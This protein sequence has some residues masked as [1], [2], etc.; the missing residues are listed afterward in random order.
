MGKIAI[1]GAGHVGGTAASFI[2][3]E[4]NCD[5]VLLDIDKDRAK[6]L[7][8]DLEHLASFENKDI[9][10]I[11]TNR[12]SDIKNSDIVI[13]AAGMPRKK[14]MKREDL[15]K[16]NISI[17]KDIAKKIRRYCKKAVIV[18]VTNPV[19]IL[20]YVV[21]KITKLPRRKIIGLGNN[22]DLARLRK[23]VSKKLG[24]K[25]RDVRGMVIGCHNSKVMV[26]LK[27]RIKIKGRPLGEVVNKKDMKEVL[28]KTKTA[29]SEIVSLMKKGSA[30]FAPAR[31]VVEL[32]DAIINNK[33]KIIPCSVFYKGVFIGLPC[34]IGKKGV[35]KII[36]PEMEE[37][38]KKE[39]EKA[40]KYLKEVVLSYKNERQNNKRTFR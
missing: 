25:V 22:L 8:L 26:I 30:Y 3:K 14:G 1:I 17:I 27:S 32:I 5:I 11:G 31:A 6:A 4:F 36:K 16:I 38:E 35:E 15:L 37:D 24:C 2:V 9:K 28:E 34:V 40:L 33:K 19:D 10:I 7:A 23:I 29:G 18:V 12:Y 13:I 39:F 20:S 21:W